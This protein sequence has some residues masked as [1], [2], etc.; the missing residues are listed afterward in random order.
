MRQ[1]WARGVPVRPVPGA[2]AVTAALSVCPLPLDGYQFVGFLPAGAAARER[3][4]ESICKAQLATVFFEAPHRIVATLELIGR[5]A[6][7]RMLMVGREL[8]KK[9]ETLLVGTAA[10]VL[11]ELQSKDALRGEFVCVL[12]GAAARN[13]GELDEA[14]LLSAL[15]RELPP[16]RAAKVMAEVC[17]G[18]RSNY[19]DRAVAAVPGRP[20]KDPPSSAHD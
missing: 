16:A 2:S 1:C 19:Y 17:G 13:R 11:A 4:L 12:A 5:I 8:T 20:G 3:R 14:R 7:Q 6:D 15:A 10:Q 9:F 18:S